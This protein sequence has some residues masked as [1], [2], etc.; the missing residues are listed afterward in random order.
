MTNPG[1]EKKIA[2]ILEKAD[3]FFINAYPKAVRFLEEPDLFVLKFTMQWLTHGYTTEQKYRI[4][5]E[6][7]EVLHKHVINHKLEI[8][9]LKRY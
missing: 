7:S 9:R 2:S 3:R 5:E 8:T 4:Y 1:Y 6:M